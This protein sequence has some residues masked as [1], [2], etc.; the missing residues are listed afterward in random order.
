MWVQGELVT[1]G[2]PVTL[3]KGWV[4]FS[5]EV[6]LDGP[7]EIRLMLLEGGPEAAEVES[8]HLWPQPPDWGLAATLNGTS[9]KHR[10][11]PFVGSSVL[12]S[13]SG[14]DTGLPIPLPGERDP[15]LIPLAPL[16][17]GGDLIRWEGE[18]FAKGGLYSMELRT[19]AHARLVLDGV[20]A[21]DLC[22]N[23]PV[24]PDSF[25]GG[26]FQGVTTTITLQEGWH[27]VRL[28]L[29]ATGNFNGLEWAWTR[30]DG[31]REIV[32]PSRLRHTQGE[33]PDP[34]TKITCL[35]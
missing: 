28:D 24:T 12:R 3:D 10:I 16:T 25:F 26:D 4:P 9:I 23:A 18:V 14:L 30:P 33:W 32:P 35:P 11:D 8:S 31:V 22:D 19:D 5:I 6:R 13:D 2:A 7:R 17:G 27:K 21:M 1:T 15:D 34:P 20:V 29:D